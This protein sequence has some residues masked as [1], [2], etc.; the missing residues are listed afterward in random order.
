MGFLRQP[1]VFGAICSLRNVPFLS[2]L[3]LL[4]SI[5][6]YPPRPVHQV[7]PAVLGMVPLVG[8]S[9]LRGGSLIDE[10][11]NKME[12]FIENLKLPPPEP[13][14]PAFGPLHLT[15]SMAAP[16][17][18]DWR[19]S[20]LRQMDK[21]E[22]EREGEEDDDDDEDE[23][24]D[25]EYGGQYSK[26]QEKW[27]GRRAKDQLFKVPSRS[28]EQQEPLEA[29]EQVLS[30]SSAEIFRRF[31]LGMDRGGRK[32]GS[33]TK[34]DAGVNILG[35]G[36]AREL[37]EERRN[38]HL[39]LIEADERSRGMKKQE[40]PVE[41]EGPAPP[42]EEE[43]L[44]QWHGPAALKN[45]PDTD[46]TS[47]PCSPAEEEELTRKSEST[48][49][50]A[51][52]LS[53]GS[54][55]T[56]Y[57]LGI[58]LERD[59]NDK[60]EAEKSYGEALRID[61][62]HLEAAMSLAR[63]LHLRGLYGDAENL[64]RH[65]L[66]RDQHHIDA[67]CNFAALLHDVLH[68]L[69]SSKQQVE[70]L[71]LRAMQNTNCSAQTYFAYAS[72]LQNTEGEAGV[73]AELYGK[74]LQEDPS[75]LPSLRAAGRLLG[76]AGLGRN[77]TLLYE[78]AVQLE[79]RHLPTR[80]NFACVLQRTC[81][82]YLE[83]LEGGRMS[84]R[85]I[86]QVEVGGRKAPV[87]DMYEEFLTEEEQK[88]HMQEL[89]SSAIKE[90]EAILKMAPHHPPSLCNLAL[91]YTQEEAGKD[92]DEIERLLLLAAEIVSNDKTRM[93]GITRD[94]RADVWCA[95]GAFLEEERGN[96]AAASRAYA[97]ALQADRNHLCTLMR[98]ANMAATVQ[99][100]YKVGECLYRHLIALVPEECDIWLSYADC[101]QSLEDYPDAE[102]AFK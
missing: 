46:N 58:L 61:K 9:R 22:K 100:D 60:E 69:G 71:F 70:A 24:I 10:K 66:S 7:A 75:H 26:Y 39:K 81:N 14:A 35:R 11:E 32:D 78:K 47:L 59:K 91:L 40:E 21:P 83:K 74:A 31:M 82:Y 67:L 80:Y 90:Y 12:E 50:A 89:R 101:L 65:V 44:E 42:N 73:I 27:G 15:W 52:E 25:D 4:T 48:L 1:A 38:R 51:I 37:R 85:R 93:P 55:E 16:E 95:Y 5:V 18:E 19:R 63:C 56:W 13:Q 2:F 77:A 64:Y 76:G 41:Q 88:Q 79:P 62:D 84:R 34:A 49:R 86:E 17:A 8:V 33:S 29:R 96:Q 87:L 57:R 53:P 20:L 23:E 102:Q 54:A 28:K 99:K 43:L 97:E 3:F 72:W 30:S 92:K 6:S 68:S 98:Y 36:I 45:S 94:F